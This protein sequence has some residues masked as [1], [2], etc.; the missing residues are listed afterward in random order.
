MN[1]AELIT[2]A[3]YKTGMTRKDTERVLNTTLEL[4]AQ[5]LKNGENVKIAGFGV[6]AVKERAEHQGRNPRTGEML[7]IPASKVVQF[8]PSKALK[9]TVEGMTVND[10][11]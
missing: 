9:E 6:F 8:R 7:T 5:E 2:E 3:A 1:K 4:M 10:E 11:N